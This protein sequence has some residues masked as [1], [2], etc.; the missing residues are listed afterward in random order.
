M[1]RET[2]TLRVYVSHV[3]ARDRVGRLGDPD[4]RNAQ[5]TP[6]TSAAAR[7]GPI[8][9]AAAADADGGAAPIRPGSDEGASTDPDERR[10]RRGV[11]RLSVKIRRA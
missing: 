3:Q 8:A 11:R 5:R 2:R 7:A 9:P 4:G 10:S 1:D 6:V